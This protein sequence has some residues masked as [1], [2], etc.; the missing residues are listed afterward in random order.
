MEP[1][2]PDG[3]MCV[4]RANIVGS[5]NGKRVLVENMSEFEQRYTVKRYR[6]SKRESAS[7][8][9]QHSGIRL[10][11]L[12]PEFESWALEEGSECRVI[13][14]FVRVLDEA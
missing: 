2:I 10:E 1:V 13:G 11:P 6:S 9:W 5:R 14:E 3:A 12:N 4:F 7:E 8:E